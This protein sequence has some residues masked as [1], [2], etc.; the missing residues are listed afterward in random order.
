M[1]G[2]I[3]KI[4]F[5]GI[6]GIG[7]SGVA[8]L[9]KYWHFQ[10]TGSDTHHSDNVIRLEKLGIPCQI[11]HHADN[12]NKS[13]L[14]VYSSAVDNNNPELLKARELG[15]P[16]IKR[17]EMLGE[18][19]RLRPNSIAVSGTHG[20]TTTTSLIGHIFSEAGRDPLIISGGIIKGLN[21]T[22]RIG[23][24]DTIIVEADEYDYSFL[25]LYPTH[26]VIT[27]IDKEHLDIYGDLQTIRDYFCKFANRIPVYGKVIVNGDDINIRKIL[28]GI[29]VPV[30]P[31]SIKN[32][33]DFQAVNIS[34]TE[35]SGQFEVI[36]NGQ[37]IGSI[38][39]PLPGTHNIQNA[40]AAIKISLE[41]GIEFETI[42]Q[43][44]RSFIGVERRF[45][46]VY[47]SDKLVLVD[48]Y[49]HH[50][51]EIRATL[52]A[53]KNG[54]KRRVIAIFQPHLYSRTEK[55]YKDFA[56]ELQIAD[57]IIILDIYPAR[58]KPKPGV[59]SQLIV[60]ILMEKHLTNFHY[61]RD[62][63]KV[64]ALIESII[65]PGDMIITLGAGD[66]NKLHKS[67][68]KQFCKDEL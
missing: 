45:D 64:P 33:S 29:S 14:V 40:L 21:S 22:V 10:V 36:Q 68:R 53:A 34:L 67:F 41:Y 9:M 28:P 5:I 8:E 38:N 55:L 49:A 15:I 43:A 23:A 58:E 62:I 48:D 24:G 39:L 61:V 16:I 18:I 26:I 1:F 11:G 46:V 57:E 65:K 6:G 52:T 35:M 30:Q 51:S 25:K 42:R 59:T 32:R 12:V 47:Q 4:H 31:Y 20:K 7:M 44:F 3:K 37:N 19:L 60:D 17:A 13:D 56:Q 63:N 54:W 66:V 50:P 27:T 2:N